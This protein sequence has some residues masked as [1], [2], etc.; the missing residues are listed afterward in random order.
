MTICQ[1]LNCS[2]RASFNI[3][4]QSTSLYC[5]IHKGPGMVNVRHR[6]CIISNCNTQPLFN[7][8]GSKKGLY[9]AKHKKD[10]MINVVSNICKCPNC[11]KH[12]TFNNSNKKSGLYCSNHKQPNMVCVT[13][14]KCVFNDCNVTP[15]FN[16]LGNTVGLYCSKHKKPGMIDVKHKKCKFDGCETIPYFNYNGNSRGLYCSKHKKPGMIDVKHKKCVIKNCNIQPLFNNPNCSKGLYCSKHKLSGM[17]NINKKCTY[18]GCNNQPHFNEKGKTNGLYCS[19]HKKPKMIDVKHKFCICKTRAHFGFIGEQPSRCSKHKEPNMIINPRIKCKQ[20]D[21]DYF[22]SYGLKLNLQEFCVDHAPNS[23]MCLTNRT[24]KNA[25]KDPICIKIDVL[26]S[27]GLCRECDPADHFK[28]RKKA[29]EEQVK[30]WLDCSEHNDYITYDKTH[31][32]FSECFGKKYRPD[33]LFDCATHYVVLEV[34]ENQHRG[35]TYEC[36]QKRMCDIAQSLGMHTIFIRYNPDAYKT[37]GNKYNPSSTKRKEYLM[38]V[39]DYCKKEI[40][41]PETCYLRLTKLYFDEFSEF[42]LDDFK[43]YQFI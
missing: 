43:I 26:N 5:S 3:E 16:S 17:I 24:C 21:C 41:M 4:G 13:K 25:D 1:N 6:K 23:Y 29:K 15:Y 35:K 38:K 36:D 18:V 19:K 22:A 27:K 37:K 20:K 30:Q 34:D 14:K 39:I 40:P 12:A 9:C 7:F 42:K 32:E 33:F 28:F 10:D 8:Y 11:K 2:K 31:P